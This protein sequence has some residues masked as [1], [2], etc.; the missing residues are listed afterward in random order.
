MF[1]YIPFPVFTQHNGDDTLP[2]NKV[3]LTRTVS[4]HLKNLRSSMLLHNIAK[5]PTHLASF[6]REGP[7]METGS[8]FP[9]HSTQL[10]HLQQ[11]DN[12]T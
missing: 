4:E 5:A 12:N 6:A 3:M 10:V 7:K 8:W 11:N 2:I 9:A 1:D